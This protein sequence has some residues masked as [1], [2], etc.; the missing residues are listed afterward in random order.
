[1]SNFLE[2]DF[3]PRIIP[4]QTVTR[5]QKPSVARLNN[6]YPTTPVGKTVV[7]KADSPLRGAGVDLLDPGN[8]TS[9]VVGLRH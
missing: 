3:W 9:V 6:S 2:A 8:A 1:M 5:P 7:L 4:G